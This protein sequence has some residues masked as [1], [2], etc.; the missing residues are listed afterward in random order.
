MSQTRCA[1]RT[2]VIM[3]ILLAIPDLSLAAVT[4]QGFVTDSA[5]PTHPV[6]N[7]TIATDYGSTTSAIDGSYS[8]TIDQSTAVYTVTVSAYGF[9][10][11]SKDLFVVDGGS[12]EHDF[13]LEIAPLSIRRISPNWGKTSQSMDV[14]ISG[15]GFS[16][17]TRIAMVLD[18]T[19]NSQIIGAVDGGANGFEIIGNMAYMTGTSYDPAS[20]IFSNVQLIDISVPDSPVTVGSFQTTGSAEDI[21]VS[22]NIAYVADGFSGLQIINISNP[23]VPELISTIDT[24]GKAVRVAISDQMIYIADSDNGLQIIDAHDPV[25]PILRGAVYST[26]NWASDVIVIGNMAYVAANA[27]QAI[28]IE[29]PDN[30]V[31]VDSLET[32]G[33]AQAISISDSKAYVAHSNDGLQIIDI[34]NPA[35]LQLLSSIPMPDT[36]SAVTVVGSTAYVA[37][38]FSGTQVVDIS[39]SLN[40]EILSTISTPNRASKITVIDNTAYIQDGGLQIVNIGYLTRSGIGFADTPGDAQAVALSG[41]TAYV[42]DLNGYLQVIDITTPEKPEIRSSLELPGWATDLALSGNYLYITAGDLQLVDI[43]TPDTPQLLDTIPVSGD[44]TSVVVKG[45]SVYVSD[46][47]SLHIFDISIPDQ[48]TLLS[49][50]PIPGG[51]ARDIA[52]SSDFAYVAAGGN[53]LQIVDIT[54][55]SSPS[56]A[57]Q[58]TDSMSLTTNVVINNNMAYVLDNLRLHI[59]DISNPTSPLRVSTFFLGGSPQALHIDNNLIYIANADFGLQAIDVSIPAEPNR[60]GTVATP[61]SSK[62]LYIAG[63]TAFMAD[64]GNGLVLL[65]VPVEIFRPNLATDSST[66]ITA[67]YL[68]QPLLVIIHSGLSPAIPVRS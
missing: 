19:N 65:P 50:L 21:S 37:A 43:S 35:N 58:F 40:P 44:P 61:G 36:A 63:D 57:G 48:P 18:L 6:V 56:L 13:Q 34:S 46:G 2:I 45:D 54:N 20:G 55:Q 28:N 12:T 8:L 64:G 42:A 39:D 38:N 60:I 53:G 68:Q 30:P 16:D 59:L 49:S 22:G 3:L 26:G 24:P 32:S 23:A 47:D 29:N 67:T 11:Q 5:D 52:V 9:S 27:F 33:V 7:A 14:V 31:I 1:T 62:G 15:T 4:F 66:T 25:N 10:T 41:N 51:S 17:N